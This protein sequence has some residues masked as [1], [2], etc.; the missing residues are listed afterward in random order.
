M[1]W[2]CCP[3]VHM[4][5]PVPLQHG[6]SSPSL[7]LGLASLEELSPPSGVFILRRLPEALSIVFNSSFC[8]SVSIFLSSFPLSDLVPTY[9]IISCPPPSFLPPLSFCSPHPQ[10]PD[11]NFHWLNPVGKQRARVPTDAVHV[12]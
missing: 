6:S 2:H 3:R 9:F 8:L 4:Q 12:G 11:L 1:R 7:C 10:P 5:G